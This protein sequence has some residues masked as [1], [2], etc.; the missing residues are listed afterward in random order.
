MTIPILKLLTRRQ[1]SRK[2]MDWLVIFE[3]ARVN[4]APYFGEQLPPRPWQWPRG[5]YLDR[6]LRKEN[7]Y[8][9]K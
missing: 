7:V 1:R 3:L 8:V 9:S 6:K 2:P 4:G 5:T